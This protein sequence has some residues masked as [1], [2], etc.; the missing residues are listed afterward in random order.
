MISQFQ[1]FK[2]LHN[3]AEPLLLGNVWN[4]QSAKVLEKLG[5]SAL[6]TSSHAV[7]ESLGY[8]DGENIP[9]DEYLMIVNRIVKSTNLPVS[10]DIESGF[11][12]TDDE[13]IENICTLNDLGVVGINI[14]DSVVN[15]RVRTLIDSTIFSKKL[16]NITTA[17][18]SKNI[19]IFI[20]VR[21]DAFLLD[22]PNKL[23]EAKT[24]LK[25]YEANTIDGIFLPCI[26]YENDIAEIIATIKTPLNV[27]G[28]PNLPDFDTLQKLGVKRISIGNFINGHIY[29][30]ME[31]TCAK[32]N[33][34][35]NFSILFQ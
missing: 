8:E 34:N 24:R 23:Q 35:R 14:E 20:N 27:L 11:G 19:E 25:L 7:A 28:L 21:C 15:D 3:Q 17:L 26:T 33:E 10:V 2:E 5:Y 13:V 16:K 1:K 6:G 32:I 29:K 22:V 4:V 12:A 9:F 18:S 30:E 31:N